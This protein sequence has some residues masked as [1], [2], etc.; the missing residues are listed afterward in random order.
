MENAN[1]DNAFE[2]LNWTLGHK[3]DD[4]LPWHDDTLPLLQKP[5][6]T[7]WTPFTEISSGFPRGYKLK[8]IIKLLL[9]QL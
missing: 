4:A 9:H 7:Q 2:T 3:R 1:A 6:F 8:E 5:S